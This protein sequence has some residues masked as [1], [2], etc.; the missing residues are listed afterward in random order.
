M[1]N[2]GMLFRSS[3][4]YG[5]L[6]ILMSTHNIHFPDNIKKKIPQNIP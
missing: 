3:I 4:I 5:M 1:D 2:L 6:A